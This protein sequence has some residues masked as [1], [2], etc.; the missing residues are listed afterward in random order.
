M[1]ARESPNFALTNRPG[2]SIA[3]RESLL[4]TKSRTAS[5]RLARDP[6]IGSSSTLPVQQ[7]SQRHLRRCARSATGLAL[8]RACRTR[9]C[10]PRGKVSSTIGGGAAR[11]CRAGMAAM[12]C[13]VSRP[14]SNTWEA[15]RPCL[16]GDTAVNGVVE[17][18]GGGYGYRSKR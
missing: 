15:A 14:V 18:G 2:R 10:N 3:D 12:R 6:A 17:S 13:A 8:E 5:R 11:A 9:S 4:A 7:I 1:D 16:S